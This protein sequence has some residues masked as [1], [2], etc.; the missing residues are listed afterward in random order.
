MTIEQLSQI[1][2][3]LADPIRLQIIHLLLD[4]ESL[5]VC[6]IVA[7]LQLSQSTTSRHLAYLKNSALVSAERRG[8]WMHY[9][10]QRE[11]LEFIKLNKLGKQLDELVV[12][13][14]K[15]NSSCCKIDTGRNDL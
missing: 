4:K 1:F 9:R 7:K 3:A 6:E 8:V 15:E 13:E 12:W 5:C 10:L 11:T 2:K 14:S